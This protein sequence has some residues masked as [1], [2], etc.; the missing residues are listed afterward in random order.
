MFFGPGGG[1]SN[2]QPGSQLGTPSDPTP[3]GEWSASVFS[4]QLVNLLR[5][6]CLYFAEE[7][8]HASRTRS[9]LRF[10]QEVKEKEHQVNQFLQKFQLTAEEKAHLKG[11]INGD[12]FAT[13][14][15]VL[16]CCGNL[17]EWKLAHV[18]VDQASCTDFQR[19]IFCVEN[20]PPKLV[21]CLYGGIGADA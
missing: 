9:L 5:R 3:G 6:C 21:L 11:D 19:L 20:I 1:T 13:L 12:F 8:P 16:S 10:V 15:K 14:A 18:G 17:Q 4:Q 2:D 7:T